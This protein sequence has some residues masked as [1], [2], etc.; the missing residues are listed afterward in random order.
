MDDLTHVTTTDASR[1]KADKSHT[2]RRDACGAC[3]YRLD[4]IRSE[5]IH[6]TVAFSEPIFN[7]IQLVC[8]W[9][10]GLQKAQ[11]WFPAQ[12]TNCDDNIEDFAGSEPEVGSQTNGERQMT[13]KGQFRA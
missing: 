2:N 4:L 7:Q 11:Q 3:A 1:I 6:L 13:R 9:L 10:R 8:A 12:T 5:A